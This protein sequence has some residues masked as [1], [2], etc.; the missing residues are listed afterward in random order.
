MDRFWPIFWGFVPIVLL[1]LISGSFV[2]N[3]LARDNK[4]QWSLLIFFVIVLLQF[5]LCIYYRVTERKLKILKTNLNSDANERIVE[6]AA[7]SL[8]WKFLKEE[9]YISLRKSFAFRHNA[10]VIKVITEDKFI[11]YNIRTQGTYKGR[12][13]HTFGFET[14][15][16]W[17]F[18]GKLRYFKNKEQL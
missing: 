12:F 18:E 14:L 1:V 4:M 15:R 5:L 6:N 13:M 9:N 2:V 17:Q 10:Y 16:K 11:Y 3:L 7:K 8:G